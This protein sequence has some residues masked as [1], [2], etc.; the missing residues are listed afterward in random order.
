[1]NNLRFG[2]QLVLILLCCHALHSRAD[3]IRLTNGRIIECS[4]LG[5][6]KDRV[7]VS[8]GSGTMT[9]NRNQIAHIEKEPHS[10]GKPVQQPMKGNILTA[11][12]APEQHADL[13]EKF[14][15]LLKLRNAAWDGRYMMKIYSEKIFDQERQVIAYENQIMTLQEQLADCARQIE[16][17][18]IPTDSPKNNAEYLEYTEKIST[19]YKLIQKQ[20]G[21]YAKIVPLERKRSDAKKQI[22]PLRLK[23]KTAMEPIPLFQTGLL[24]FSNHYTD[25]TN[26]I[27]MTGLKPD[28]KTFFD[29]INR[30]LDKFERENASAEIPIR[31]NGNATYVQAV[32]NG[33]TVGEF[34][35]DTGAEVMTM[36]ETFAKKLGFDLENLPMING[37][38]ADGSRTKGRYGFLKTVSVGSEQ[39]EQVAVAIF[40]DFE[41]E[42]DGLLG[43]SFLKHFSVQ[44]NATAGTVQLTPVNKASTTH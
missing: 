41:N 16:E 34:L 22:P 11:R 27:S 20:E 7:I 17:M 26:S 21:L 29:K 14:R 40:P 25:Y 8:V 39:V 12:H 44:V 10:A 32:L 35:L 4:I 38:L 36:N 28:E 37:V 18:D 30:Y 24:Q 5:E 9:L 33:T 42:A 23:Y 13:A 3:R 1:M 43:M 31:Q 2:I 15:A 19:Q 6:N